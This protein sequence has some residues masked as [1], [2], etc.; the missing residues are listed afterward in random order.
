MANVLLVTKIP[1]A[2]RLDAADLTRLLESRAIDKHRLHDAANCHDQALAVVRS[3]LSREVVRERTVESVTVQDTLDIDVLVSVGGDG[4]VFTAH[5]L[6]CEV[7]YLTV[8]SDPEHSIGHFTRATA[9][10]FA[11]IYAAYRSGDHQLELVP[12]L[13]VTVAERSWRILNDCLFSSRNPAA[14]SKYLLEVDGAAEPQ[15]SSGV[16]IATA[17]G[18]T[19]AIH[20]AGATPVASHLEA[21]LFRVRE[22]FQGRSRSSILEGTQLP[23]RGLRLTPATP[24]LSLYIDGPNISCELA[25]GECVRFTKAATPLRLVVAP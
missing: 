2:D 3:A 13:Q 21:L 25:A 14:M 12:R 15:R 24:G 11:S 16:W 1:L 4:T 10:T 8:N 18:S 23:P 7:P 9:D 5:A 20:S 19:A 6:G 17:S 22:P